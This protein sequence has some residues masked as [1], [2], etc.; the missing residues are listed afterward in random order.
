MT[1]YDHFRDFRRR[2]RWMVVV[3][4]GADRPKGRVCDCFPTEL[5]KK[6]RMVTLNR[7]NCAQELIRTFI[8]LDLE[9]TGLPYDKPV[10]ITEIAMVAALREDIL[11][12]GNDV[13]CDVLVPRVLSKLTICVDPR[14]SVSKRAAELTH[15]TNE[16]LQH[17]SPF[18]EHLF[19]MLNEFIERLPQPVCFIAHNGLRFDFP[20]IQAELYRIDKELPAHIVCA[21]SLSGFRKLL[22][23]TKHV[24]GC[25]NKPITTEPSSILCH[26]QP[27]S[28]GNLQDMKNT[29]D[30]CAEFVSPT[31][32]W[33][34]SELY[35]NDYD[36][37][38]CLLPVSEHN[39]GDHTFFDDADDD[40]CRAAVDAVERMEIT[41][42]CKVIILDSPA[43]KKNEVSVL[44][45]VLEKTPC[46]PITVRRKHPYQAPCDVTRRV[47]TPRSIEASESC[48]NSS[49]Q[50]RK[51]LSFSSENSLQIVPR[52]TLNDVYRFLLKKDPVNSHCAEKDFL[53]LL[54]CIVKMGQSFTDWVDKNAVQFNSVKKMG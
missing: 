53:S 29:N 54:E 20:V 3:L 31:L 43:V 19:N 21:D 39:L 7:Q 15:L 28:I 33:E 32:E 6:K 44:Q 9:T 52:F 18:D 36:E 1:T 35:L 10:R 22:Q 16:L 11:K 12:C 51:R 26:V 41:D 14:R 24:E 42:E 30:T 50:V 47:E 25:S 45:N 13:T 34:Q 40:L 5:Q 4:I 38:L 48:L 46:R 27:L 2:R 37:A 8:I 23:T 49:H 17:H